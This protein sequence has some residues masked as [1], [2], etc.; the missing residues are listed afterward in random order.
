[1]FAGMLVQTELKPARRPENDEHAKVLH[2]LGTA[3]LARSARRS[4]R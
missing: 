1:M 3:F 2:H 4:C